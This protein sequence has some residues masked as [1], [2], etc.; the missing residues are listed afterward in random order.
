MTD[1]AARYARA[2]ALLP[3]NL[4]R[5]VYN[6]LIVPQT[7]PGGV[8]YRVRTRAGWRFVAVDTGTRRKSPAF[9][10]DA[11]AAALGSRLGRKVAPGDLPFRSIGFEGGDVIMTLPEGRMRWDGHILSNAPDPLPPGA[12]PAPDGR[13]A[14]ILIDHNLHLVDLATGQKRPLTHDGTAGHAYGA[15]PG[16]T[17]TALTD[18]TEPPAAAWSPDGRHLLVFRADERAVAPMPI[19]DH[20]PGSGLRPA[21]RAYTVPLPGDGT[22]CN[23]GYVV[24]D[25]ISGHIAPVAIPAFAAM[26]SP[27]W[28]RRQGLNPHDCWA[29]GRLTVIVRGPGGRTQTLWQIDPTTGDARVLI[30]ERSAIPIRMN[31]FEFERPN[32][33][34]MSSGEILWPS[35]ADGGT[36]LYLHDR[37]GRRLNPVGGAAHALRDIVHL[38][39]AA[40]M[41]WFTAN[42][43]A[44]NPYHRQLLRAPLDGGPAERLTHE[45]AD[46]L[47]WPCPDGEHV[48]DL[49]GRPDMPSRAVL[50]DRDGTEVLQLEEADTAD[51]DGQGHVAPEIFCLPGADGVTPVWGSLHLPPDF[52]PAR[53]YPVVNAIYGWSQVTV[54]P[55]GF[56]L[57]TSSPLTAGAEI[58]AE[59]ALVPSATAALGFVV[60]VIDGRGTPYR[61]KA[62][63]APAFLDPEMATGLAD[64]AAVIRGLAGTRPWMDLTRVGVFGHSGGGHMAAKAMLLQNDLY[65]V[66]IA[67]A[68]CHEMGVY[69]AGW[70]DQWGDT[71]DDLALRSVGRHAARLRG[72][73]LLAHG[74]LDENVHPAHTMRLAADLIAA[75][76]DFDLLILPGRHH[77]FTLDPY[78]VRRRWDYLVRHLLGE[79]PPGTRINP[80]NWSDVL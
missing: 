79:D 56:L 73:L 14:V 36:R 68:G 11:L 47:I 50:R 28:F 8:W 60:V 74:D 2:E 22:E 44:G 72:R 18:D 80:G 43:V 57:D 54:V 33:R 32:V 38:D 64:H 59:N 58:A 26:E 3:G 65:S 48:V 34:L 62:F 16:G 31:P 67:S 24:I 7:M 4:L 49:F 51:L 52:D 66:G 29:G 30:E 55:H 19:L 17:M 39:E 37:T 27:F 41:V 13:R 35:E 61:D 21:I 46:H 63:H 75:D 15:E 23:G 69:H 70:A 53:R 77:D 12:L 71:P 40:R 10:H 78:F 76:R 42:G 25:T 9:D 45:D 6:W 1:I 5:H 20:V